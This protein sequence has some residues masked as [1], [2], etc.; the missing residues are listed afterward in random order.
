MQRE[1]VES[2]VGVLYELDDEYTRVLALADTE[3]A[4]RRVV[5]LVPAAVGVDAAF[6]GEASPDDTL[7]LHFLARF[8]TTAMQDLVVRPGTGLAARVLDL[9]APVWVTDYLA[10]SAITH[11]YDEAVE[12]E[13][14]HGMIAV[15]VRLHRGEPWV[16]YGACRREATFGDRSAKTMVEAARRVALAVTVAERE[17]HAAEIAVHEERR[18]IALALHDSVG[19]MLFAIGAGARNLESDGEISPSVRERLAEIERQTQDATAALRESLRALSA[20]PE[21]LALGI[22]LRADCKSFEERTGVQTRLLVMHDLPV[23]DR[24]R[25]KVLVDATREALLNVE[26]HASASSVVVSVFAVGEGIRVAIADDGLGLG[27]NAASDGTGLGIAAA[28]ERMEQL[29]GQLVLAANDDGG[30]TVKMWVPC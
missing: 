1:R 15:P 18:R 26:K 27:A 11:D 13:G 3:A 10:A 24:A 21:E 17:R 4:I 16:L 25:T 5:E 6:V 14:L 7:A 20:S 12:I 23:L 2:D 30:V 29:G 9:E 28:A 22:A 19:A 8:R